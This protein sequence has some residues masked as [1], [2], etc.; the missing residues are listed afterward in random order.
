MRTLSGEWLRLEM[1]EDGTGVVLED[2]VR[3]VRWRLD[4]ST[5]LAARDVPR[6]DRGAFRSSTRDARVAQ[7]QPGEAEKAGEDAIRAI[8]PSPCGSV[9][10][11]WVV[12]GDGLRVF[13]EPEGANGATALALP[14][15]F[16]PE[17]E[18]GFLA[19][20]PLGQGVL[21]TGKGPEFYRILAGHGHGGGL[22]LSM[23]GQIAARGGLVA[24]GETNLDGRVLWE[25]AG[26]GQVRLMWCQLPSLGGLGY[27]R[28][29]VL[30]PTD[31][32]LTALCK[33]YR[34][35]V[36]EK[37]DPRLFWTIKDAKWYSFSNAKRIEW[38]RRLIDREHGGLDGIHYDVLCCSDM[39]ED[40]HPAHRSDA[41]AD[42]EAR[43]Q[44]LQYAAS[45]GLIV[46]S[47]GF[48]DAMAPHYDLGSTKFAHILGG[49]EYCTV[50]MTMLVYHDSMIHMWW[51][52]DN[53]NN[54]EHRTQVAR[55]HAP[56]LF[57]GGGSPRL[58]SAIDALLGCPPD[59]FP[60]GLQYNYVP[61][62]HPNVYTYRFRLEHESVREAIEYAKPVMALHRRTP[63]AT[64]ASVGAGP[65]A[66]PSWGRG[67]ARGPAPTR[68]PGPRWRG[69]GNRLRR[70]DARP[71]QLRQRRPR[72]ACRRPPAAGELAGIVTVEWRRSRRLFLPA[73]GCG[74]ITCGLRRR[75]RDEGTG[76]HYGGPGSLPWTT[77]H[78]RHADHGLRH[79]SAGR[80]RHGVGGDPARISG[81]R[82]RRHRTGSALRSVGFL[83][84]GSP[85][86]REGRHRG[87]NSGSSPT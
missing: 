42:A 28:E 75:T 47:E 59:L 48:W 38:A 70:R 79:S 9:V 68:P 86:P 82:G 33:R 1:E 16:R 29:T 55:G 73:R 60:F 14:G 69:P 84:Q 26:D 17:G 3:R 32:S 25:K 43:K 72:I 51:E 11:R 22:N 66:C 50:P 62:N 83:R 8:H 19:A 54:P 52:V 85:H 18:S 56:R 45:K 39:R 34:Q 63:A 15:T 53:Y 7:L 12:G 64:R 74:I 30:L 35:Y 31:S 6:S 71:R 44:M 67:R 2:T 10:L 65:C 4:E 87:L 41:R 5:R 27:P 49:D 78:P 21:H 81:G 61:H 37:G 46:P 76:P 36:I 20:V 80:Q 24:V 77:D 13:A 58:Q 57:W 23:F 40:Y